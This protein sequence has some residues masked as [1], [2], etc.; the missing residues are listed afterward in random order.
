MK[1]AK[2]LSASAGSGKTYQLTLKYMCDVILHP[3]RYRNILAVTFTNKAT[4]EMKSRILREIH[5]LASGNN[6]PYLNDIKRELGIS[7]PQIREGAKRAR[8]RILHDFSRFTILTIDRFFQRILRA[9]IKELSLDLNYNIELDTSLLLERS[10]DALV[11]SIATDKKLREW[12]LEFAEERIN[13]GTRWDMRN[14]L[15]S[16]GSELFKENGAKRIDPQ[17]NKATLYERVNSV[18]AEGDQYRKRLKALGDSAINTMQRYGVT[19]AEFK[20]GSRSFVFA[21]E[22]YAKG[23]LKPPT[24]TMLKASESISEWYTKGA[25]GN[26]ITASE[27]LMPTLQEIC[28][29]YD[30]GI[31]KINT[32]KLIRDNYR[33]FALLADLREKVNDICNEENIM[34]LSKTKDILSEFIDDN[35]APFIYE[36]VGSRYDHY[37]I[38]EFQDTS[39]REWRNMLPLLREALASNPESSVFIVGDIKQSI[40]R[41]R[42]GDWRLLNGDAMKDLG[43]EN[44]VLEHLQ[45]NYRSLPNIVEFNNQLINKVVTKDND[46]LNI[47]LNNALKESKIEQSTYDSLYDIMLNAYSDYEQQPG[48]ECGKQGYAEVVAFDSALSDSPFI[49]AI[50]SAMERGYRYSD[51]LILVRGNTDAKKVAD[52]L[53]AYKYDKFTSKGLS[54]FNI[55]T[56]GALTLESCDIAEFVTSVMR[57]AIDPSNDIERGVYNRHLNLPL[58]HI[59]DEEEIA[60]LHHTAHLSPLEAFESIVSRFELNNRKE[61]IAFLQ[62]MHEQILAFSSQRVVDIQYYLKWW[63]ER[64]KHEAITVEMTEDTIEITTIHKSKGL[65]RPIVIIPYSRWDMTPRASLRPIV[66]AKAND[67]EK[68]ATVGDFPIVYGSMMENSNFSEEYYKELVMSHVDGVNLLYVAI[69]RASRELYIYVPTTL[70]SKS[71]SG[72]NINT[73]APLI[74]DAAKSLCP[75]PRI[76]S[77]GSEDISYIYSYGELTSCDSRANRKT[78]GDILLDEYISH[79]P[80]LKVRYPSHR[81]IDE[82]ITNDSKALS[83]GIRLHR[84]FERAITEQDLRNAVKR[85]SLDCLIDAE[86]AESLNTKISNILMDSRVKEWFSEQWDSVKCENAIIYGGEI[87]RPDRVMISGDRAVVVDYKFGDKRSSVYRKQIAEYMRLLSNMGKYNRIEGYVW[88]ISLG[89]I[90]SIEL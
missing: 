50:E 52:A 80:T 32:A 78:N 88:Y 43:E 65:E 87:R 2:I 46:F 10:T 17:L 56:P 74:L 22:K 76:V 38:D 53:F 12:L 1:R 68:S 15:K 28:L 79:K 7:E 58:D 83:D 48:K 51:I 23:E 69:T 63:N 90:E 40:Y 36:K 42:G 44:T 24:A 64:G 82:G 55:L 45:N 16:L 54:G 20:G 86:Q 34:V 62:A 49:Q 60:W 59:F 13:D 89:E 30:E 33:S 26:V 35:N 27:V 6:S 25:S 9:F 29:C 77:T 47:N 41:W 85:M 31:K 72:E 4:E 8:T 18:I 37:M 73:T 3:E 61:S 71:K 81:C 5:T 14:D 11:E 70:N 21:F 39:V 75:N 66:W 19:P 67:N 84:L 57:L